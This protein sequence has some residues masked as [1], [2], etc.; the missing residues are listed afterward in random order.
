MKKL[1][2]LFPKSIANL[3]L[4]LILCLSISCQPNGIDGTSKEE[5]S[6]AT[7]NSTIEFSVVGGV[8]LPK[9]PKLIKK[10]DPIYPKIASEANIEG[11][12][13]LEITTDIN[14]K[15][16]DAKVLQSIPLLD[17]AAIDAAKKWVFE[18]LIIDG[19]RRSVIL[20]VI[21]QFK[22]KYQNSLRKSAGLMN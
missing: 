11:S 2:A 4:I 16:Q 18:P 22:L 20:T 10:V 12:V 17:Q 14:G 8:G 9:P 13:I 6:K 5:T 19:Q 15:V 1:K 21:V 7:T 3:P